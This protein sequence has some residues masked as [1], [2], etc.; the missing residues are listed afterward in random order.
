MP[1]SFEILKRLG[2]ELIDLAVEVF[3][4]FDQGGVARMR[5][6]PQIGVT[7]VLIDQDS[8]ADGNQ[9]VVATDDE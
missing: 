7:K 6:D 8:V 5:D 4:V 1:G 3:G 2:E 9:V